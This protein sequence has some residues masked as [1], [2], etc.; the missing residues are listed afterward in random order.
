MIVI[1]TE[2]DDYILC[3]SINWVRPKKPY[4]PGK[5]GTHAA[6]CQMHPEPD[7]RAEQ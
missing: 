4:L 7:L 5:T 6:H 1:T 2:R 3:D